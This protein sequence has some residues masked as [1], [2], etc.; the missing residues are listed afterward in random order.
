MTALVKAPAK[1]LYAQVLRANGLAGRYARPVWLIGDG[2]SGTTWIAALMNPGGRMREMFEPVH[3]C[4]VPE[5][6]FLRL[7]AYRAPGTEDP[8][9]GALAARIFTGRLTDRRVDRENRRLIFDGLLVKD[10]FAGMLAGWVAAARPE[11]R[12]VL[13]VRNPFAVARSK[14]ALTGAIWGD[15]AADLLAQPD[16]MRDHL[17]PQRSLLDRVAAGGEPLMGYLALWAALHTVLSRQRI[18][19]MPV[20]FYED[21]VADP[22]G[23]IA[24]VWRAL[25]EDP[26]KRRPEAKRIV[27]PSWTSTGEGAEAARTRPQEAWRRGLGDEEIARG[28][29]LLAAFGLD[30]LYGADGRPDRAEARRLFGE[31][32]LG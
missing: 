19:G 18:A 14:R 8:A 32:A 30:R 9:L 25:G 21:A 4:F 1:W 3:P 2:R 31:A 6:G 10:V 15:G 16:L 23:E 27:A 13:L 26:A 17:E 12:P 28:L 5:A 24:R 29:E 11:V 22:E 20:L 7:N